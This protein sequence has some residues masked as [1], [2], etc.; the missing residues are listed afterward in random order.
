[1][2]LSIEMTLRGVSAGGKWRNEGIMATPTL[3]FWAAM[4]RSVHRREGS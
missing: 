3:P 2:S 4:R 1:M